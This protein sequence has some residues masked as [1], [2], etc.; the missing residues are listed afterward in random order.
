EAARLERDRKG[1][2]A[3]LLLQPRGD[4]PNHARM[5]ALGG[6]DHDRA[7]VLG[8]ERRERFRLGLRDGLDLDCLALAVEPGELPGEPC[9]VDLILVE[10]QI[11]AKRRATDA[12]A[13]I[14]ARAEQKAQ[15]PWLRRP[16]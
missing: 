13:R 8:A 1:R 15:V 9:R 2:P 12:A 3:E 11:N 7:L 4:E 14:D 6:G 10:Q 16:G 5:P